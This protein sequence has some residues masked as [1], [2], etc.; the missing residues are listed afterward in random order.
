[1][2]QGTIPGAEPRRNRP[3]VWVT[4]LTKLLSG[5][6][7]CWWAAWYRAH[8][9]FAKTP[10]DPGRAEFFAEYTAAHDKIAARRAEEFRALG[11]VVR[12]EDD[13]AFKLVGRDADL[14]GKPDLVAVGN[15]EAV[16]SD[17]KGGKRRESD[18]WQVRI[19]L[20]GLPL[21][22]LRG[23]KLRGEVEY[24]DGRIDVPAPTPAE[25]DA[26]V[27]AMRVV[28]GPDAPP[29]TPSAGECRYCDVAACTARHKAEDSSG[30]ARA[31]F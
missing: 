23:V 10:D 4:W 1:M 19:Y 11:Y 5:E 7:K 22:W 28:S 31:Y 30:D 17:V 20:F 27:Q 24:R 18:R 9:K 6:S 29:P 26:I 8:H 3:Y 12:Q 15:G 2:S 14:A 21:S 25:R 16:A 13:A